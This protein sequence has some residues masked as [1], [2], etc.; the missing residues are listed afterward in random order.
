[1]G[2]GREHLEF[3]GGHGGFRLSRTMPGRS[4]SVVCRA[5]IVNC[6]ECIAAE[7]TRQVL[8][9]SGGR[10][11][12]GLS[13]TTLYASHQQV[14]PLEVLEASDVLKWTLDHPRTGQI[15]AAV[16]PSGFGAWG[17]L[18][19]WAGTRFRRWQSGFRDTYAVGGVEPAG[20]IIPRWLFVS[21]GVQRMAVGWSG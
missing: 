16:Q 1:M 3:M 14:G 5:W 21:V 15:Q 6:S 8:S 20:E 9:T 12:P 19:C 4:F 11:N 2:R 10:W 17:S 18:G 7:L 13:L